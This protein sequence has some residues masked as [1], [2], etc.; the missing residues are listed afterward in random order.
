VRVTT[1][2]E[3]LPA[4]AMHG[5][6]VVRVESNGGNAQIDVVVET[7]LVARLQV[8]NE[9]V[10][11]VPRK[12]DQRLQGRLTIKNIGRA[13]ARAELRTGLPELLLTRSRCDIKPGKSARIVVRWQGP[14]QPDPD[15]MYVDIVSD[16]QEIRVPA[17]IRGEAL[18]VKSG[19]LG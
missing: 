13:T 15:R 4:G 9:V 5:S 3:E 1:D 17:K 11:L 2:L 10:E 18:D 19:P 14:V 12:R 16:G 8:V 7:L 6:G